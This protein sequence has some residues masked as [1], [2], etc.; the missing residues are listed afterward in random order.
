MGRT[1][2]IPI[3]IFGKSLGLRS[4]WT[5]TSDLGL[6]TSDLRSRRP[7]SKIQGPRYEIQGLTL[8]GQ[9]VE[10][11]KGQW[12]NRTDSQSGKLPTF[13]IQPAHAHV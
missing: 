1:R 13:R 9:V 7:R 8:R 12:S 3:V 10:N 4:S 6:Q 5:S 2:C 11:L